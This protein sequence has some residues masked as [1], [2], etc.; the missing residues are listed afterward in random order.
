MSQGS[1]RAQ[2]ESLVNLKGC[3]AFDGIRIAVSAFE[4]LVN[5]KGCKAH[6]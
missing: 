4:S 3:K 5:L 2:F 1:R 6:A